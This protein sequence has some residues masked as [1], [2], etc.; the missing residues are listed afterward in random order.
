MRPDTVEAAPLP[1]RSFPTPTGRL[2]RALVYAFSAVAGIVWALVAYVN[3]PMMDRGVPGA[4]AWPLF[5]SCA[6]VVSSLVGLLTEWRAGPSEEDDTPLQLPAGRHLRHLVL[7]VASLLLYYALLP[8]L[9]F[10]LASVAMLFACQVIFLAP[11]R[12]WRKLAM[13]LVLG[14]AIHLLFAVVLDF[15]LPQGVLGLL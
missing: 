2:L 10:L 4:G 5:L 8:V 7:F 9:G 13:A 14:L 1:P 11:R 3:L 6:V 12:S 15:S